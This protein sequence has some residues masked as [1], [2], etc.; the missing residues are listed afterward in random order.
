MVIK[1]ENLEKE[2]RG[3]LWNDFFNKLEEEREDFAVASRAKDYVLEDELISEVVWNGRE[4][5]NSESKV[6]S[7]HLMV[8]KLTVFTSLP[9]GCCTRGVSL[10]SRLT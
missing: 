10:L 4:I 6:I 8:Y 3:R 2:E 5:R 7:W 1:Y 9:N